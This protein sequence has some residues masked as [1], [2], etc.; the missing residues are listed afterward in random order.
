VAGHTLD[1][2]LLSHHPDGAAINLDCNV[3]T[4]RLHGKLSLADEDLNL[5][6][7]L[8]GV[9]AGGLKG[10]NKNTIRHGLGAVT[11]E[12]MEAVIHI[13]LGGAI[14]KG[15][16]V[17]ALKGAHWI[18]GLASNGLDSHSQGIGDIG[19]KGFWVQVGERIRQG[20]IPEFVLLPGT[21]HIGDLHINGAPDRVESG[22]H[23][24]LPI[25]R[26]VSKAS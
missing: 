12:E 22:P 1:G 21:G 4:L 13:G 9:A 3:L 8:M 25:L 19:D 17:F 11:R 7:G 15:G 6:L 10:T 24:H 2:L 5:L 14:V 20:D 26:S 16:N 18:D 23:L